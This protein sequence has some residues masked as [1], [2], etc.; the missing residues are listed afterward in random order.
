MSQ[1]QDPRPDML[2]HAFARKGIKAFTREQY[3]R[4]GMLDALRENRRRNQGNPHMRFMGEAAGA[5]ANDLR[6]VVELP[7]ADIAT[8]LLAAGGL[9]G[10]LAEVR[11]LRGI[12]V[13]GLL[14]CIADELD[15]AANGGERS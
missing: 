14:Q 15:Q 1:A 9:V 4:Q 10:V 3:S 11:G 8:V 2:A 12:T 6:E 5:V 13:A 7:A